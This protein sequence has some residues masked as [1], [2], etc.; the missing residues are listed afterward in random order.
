[1]TP[2]I[3]WDYRILG[4]LGR[5]DAASRPGNASA[6]YRAPGKLRDPGSIF[7]SY[8]HPH[9]TDKET[10][11]R[12][13]VTVHSELPAMDSQEHLLTLGPHKDPVG[14]RRLVLLKNWVN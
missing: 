11:D 12:T 4:P 3:V 14:Y 2:S 8:Q 7:L 10:E 5:P 9:F 1:M 6:L 13:C